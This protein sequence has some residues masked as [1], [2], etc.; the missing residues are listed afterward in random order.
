MR[1]RSGVD[2]DDLSDDDLLAIFDLYVF[3]KYRDLDLYEPNDYD[4]KR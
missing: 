3:K 1:C 2:M 4:I